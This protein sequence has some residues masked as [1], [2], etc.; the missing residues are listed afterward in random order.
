MNFVCEHYR[1]KEN[2][3]VSATSL[4]STLRHRIAVQDRCLVVKQEKFPAAVDKKRRPIRLFGVCI[5]WR[6][7]GLQCL[8]GCVIENHAAVSHDHNSIITIGDSRK[9]ADSVRQRNRP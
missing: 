1:T 5:L 9:A 8:S 3:S 2:S 4:K 6:R 7:G